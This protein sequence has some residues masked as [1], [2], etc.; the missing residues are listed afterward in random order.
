LI[1]TYTVQSASDIAREGE[2]LRAAVAESIA[3][4]DDRIDRLRASLEPRDLDIFDAQR[5]IFADPTILK[6]VQ[7]KIQ[8]QHLNA[9]A[10]WQEILS[11]Y[12]ADQ[13]KSDDPYL[14]VRAAD[15][16]EVERTVVA[17]LV[18][19][20]NGSGPPV[21]AFVHPTLLVCEELT[22]TLAERFRRLSIAGVIQLGGGPTSHGAILAR[23]LGLPAVG[24]A[25]KHLERLRTAQQVAINGSEGSLWIDPPTDLQAELVARQRLERSESHRAIEG[26]QVRSLP[27]NEILPKLTIPPRLHS[28][29]FMRASVGCRD[30]PRLRRGARLHRRVWSVPDHPR[31]LRV[32]HA[33]YARLAHDM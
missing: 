6:E 3:A 24:G 22:P 25:R 10:A 17:H 18:D 23:A 21:E 1:P 29:K 26:S 15:F 32:H 9:A 5:M 27:K 16:R 7:A 30:S 31:P 14:R 12:A 8:E 2:K 28:E 11:R 19:E 33:P 4:F 20:Q 13:E